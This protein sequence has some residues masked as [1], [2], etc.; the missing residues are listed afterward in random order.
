MTV[1]LLA[2]EGLALVAL[3]VDLSRGYALFGPLARG[4]LLLC[5]AIPCLLVLRRR[6]PAGV[7]PAPFLALA[8]GCAALGVLGLVENRGVP[9]IQKSWDTA[10]RQRLETE[11]RA[12]ESDFASF[13]ADLSDP[14]RKSLATFGEP[15]GAF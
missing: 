6:R 15:R 3:C 1:L 5:A 11:A 4:A 14:L 9:V 10:A 8:A 2:L 12:I 13:L 7:P